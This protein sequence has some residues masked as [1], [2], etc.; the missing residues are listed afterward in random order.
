MK[1][2]W[3]RLIRFEAT[4]GRI[5]YGEPILPREDFD[6]GDTDEQTGLK[7]RV[8]QGNDLYDESGATKVTDEIVTVK[9]LLGPLT[10]DTVPI[11]RAIGL[12]YL[13]HRK[14]YT[15]PATD[16]QLIM[17]QCVRRASQHRPIPPCS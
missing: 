5:L 7:A 3:A 14:V 6:L 11:I 17:S 8:I 1:T 12:N 10:S 16:L 9:E 13:A 15:A 2:A 4:D